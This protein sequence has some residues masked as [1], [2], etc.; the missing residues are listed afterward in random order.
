M[1][2]TWRAREGVPL[3]IKGPAMIAVDG[4][5]RDNSNENKHDDLLQI[6]SGLFLLHPC[7]QVH[8]FVESRDQKTSG[9]LFPKPSNVLVIAQFS[10]LQEAICVQECKATSLGTTIDSPTRRILLAV[11]GLS[12]SVERRV[13]S[14]CH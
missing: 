1:P 9:S 3:S 2:R 6:G 10:H 7:P 8:T 12:R 4:Y 5:A 14:A 11:T 13:P